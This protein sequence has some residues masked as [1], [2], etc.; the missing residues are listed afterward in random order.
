VRERRF[1]RLGWAVGEVGYGMW[2]VGAGPGGWVGAD[3]DTSLAAMQL[4]V[5][6]GC[7]LFDTAW[8]Y[9]RGHSEKLLGRLLEANPGAGLRV[10]TKIPPKDRAWP[11][12]RRSRLEDVFPHDHVLEYTRASLENLGVDR[13][14]LMQF[15]V[16]EDGWTADDRW[17]ATV[18][19][20]RGSGMV[21]GIGISV[22]RW[23]PWNAVAAV[24]SGLVDA[25]QV[26]YNIFDQNPEDR[27]LP[28]CRKHD[29]AVIARVPFDEGSLTGTL[30]EDSVWPEGDWRA[31]YFV[32][33]NL[34][35]SVAHADA[36]KPLV[37]AGMTLPELALRFILQNPDISTVIPGM[38]RPE[39]VRANLGVSDGAALG[40]GLM[41]RLREHRWDRTPT[42]WSQ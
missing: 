8:I 9:G 10:C 31:L 11:S 13:T 42:E 15:H 14:G 27:L 34:R 38:R 16:W 39:H 35:D 28:A 24:E 2:G 4:G 29:V 1:G 21:D 25:V 22:N 7:T 37:P 19:E 23:E 20:L 32:P 3:D 17:L 40:P 18:A 5:D 36:L 26:I 41:A 30:T 12:T 6:L 33:E